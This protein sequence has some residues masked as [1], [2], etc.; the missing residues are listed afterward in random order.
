MAAPLRPEAAAQL[1][2]RR[3]GRYICLEHHQN[4]PE[5]A[6]CRQD[7]ASKQALE[8]HHAR[9]SCTPAKLPSDRRVSRLHGLDLGN[10][11]QVRRQSNRAAVSKYRSTVNGERAVFR[12]RHLAKYQPLP[13]QCQNVL[14]QRR[15]NTFRRQSLGC[16]QT[17]RFPRRR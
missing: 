11:R 1:W 7:F 9:T 14:N 4:Q 8:T 13:T 10:S 3:N 5:D 6:S 17:L 2:E 12:A 15:Q 16:L